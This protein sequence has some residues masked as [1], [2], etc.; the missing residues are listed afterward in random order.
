MK[1]PKTRRILGYSRGNVGDKNDLTHHIVDL[2]P[3]MVCQRG[4]TTAIYVIEWEMGAAVPHHGG[5]DEKIDHA[6]SG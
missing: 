2:S 1:N 4:G 3:T 6:E 5:V